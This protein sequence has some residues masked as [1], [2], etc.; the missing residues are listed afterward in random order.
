MKPYKPLFTLMGLSVAAHAL[1]AQPASAA[2]Q[3]AGRFQ[4]A[5][6]SG[7]LENVLADFQR[8]TGL[9][10]VLA[11]P[12]LA[13]IQSPGV[14]GLL[15]PAEAM[16]QDKL[17]NCTARWNQMRAAKATYGQTFEQFSAQCTTAPRG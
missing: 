12:E 3:A 15:T 4:F 11:M 6:T 9:K 8:V 16:R 7:S 14:T 17:A 13:M 10:A 2:Q 5:I 1:A